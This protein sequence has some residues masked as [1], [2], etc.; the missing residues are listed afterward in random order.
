V[1][2]FQGDAFFEMMQRHLRIF[3]AHVIVI[4]DWPLEALGIF[5]VQN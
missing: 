3:L 2:T 1:W 4:L 5:G